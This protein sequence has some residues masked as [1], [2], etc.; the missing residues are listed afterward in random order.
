MSTSLGVA[1]KVAQLGVPHL[2]Q[3][4]VQGQHM[5]RDCVAGLAPLVIEIR[6]RYDAD[7]ENSDR[8]AEVGLVIQQTRRLGFVAPSHLTGE[9]ETIEHVNLMLLVTETHHSSYAAESKV[10]FALQLSRTV[11]S[12]LTILG[13]VI[14]SAFLKRDL[15]TPSS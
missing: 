13:P 5:H 6:L 8:V 7:E 9:R 14:S 4:V 2:R 1:T 3:L 11:A 12:Y 15:T 10:R